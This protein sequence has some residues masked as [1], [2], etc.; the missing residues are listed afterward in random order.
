MHGFQHFYSKCTVRKFFTF[1]MVVMIIDHGISN[2]AIRWKIWKSIKVKLYIFILAFT[3]SKILT[4][5]IFKLK[6][7]G[8]GHVVQ[9]LQWCWLMVNVK[10]YKCLSCIF[11]LALNVSN[12]LFKIFYLDIL[13][14]GHG[15]EKQ[16]LHRLI[17]NV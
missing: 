4:F 15:G 11:A 13:G 12:I 3:I 14:K 5:Q 6:S 7:L 10:I 8:Q 1:K 16:N 9:H 17:S 2:G